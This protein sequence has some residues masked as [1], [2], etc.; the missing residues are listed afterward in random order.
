MSNNSTPHI[1]LAIPLS[2]PHL[3]H[4]L[5]PPTSHHTSLSPSLSLFPI[6]ITPYVYQLHATHHSRH[7]SLYSTAKSPS[8]SH[9]MSTNFTPHITLA[10]PL[11]IPRQN[12]H[13]HHTLCPPTSHHTS[14]SPSLSLF[15]GKIPICITPYVHQLHTT[16]H[17]HHPSLYS[18]SASHPMSTNF[19]P[20]I[21]LAIPL[22]I[23]RQNPHLHHTLCPPASHHTSLSP[24]LSLFPGKIPICIT[25]Y[26]HQLHITLAIP[27]SIPR[28]NP[29]P[30]VTQTPY[31][32]SM[33]TARKNQN[34]VYMNCQHQTTLCCIWKVHSL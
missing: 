26:V 11:S 27:L 12:P 9:P 24:S 32:T 1:T 2:I 16:H 28:Q 19:T 20:H 21:T 34:T 25:P 5:Y 22:S 30:V 7:P 8:A 31:L 18:P 10:I 33:T 6:C 29:H 4:T 17:S 3:H 15:P 13:L 23:P 14:L